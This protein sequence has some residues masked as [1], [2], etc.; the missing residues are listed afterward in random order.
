MKK[1]DEQAEKELIEASST[2]PEAATVTTPGPADAP[3]GMV[4]MRAPE[5]HGADCGHGGQRYKIEKDGTA[6]VDMAAVSDLRSLGYRT[7]GF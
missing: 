7:T 1:K 3:V 5:R 6:I 4:R 2:Q